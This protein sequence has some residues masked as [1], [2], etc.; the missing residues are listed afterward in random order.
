MMKRT[1]EYSL[2]ETHLSKVINQ[3]CF[4][5]SYVIKGWFYV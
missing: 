4:K 5:D 2:I 1:D 3:S